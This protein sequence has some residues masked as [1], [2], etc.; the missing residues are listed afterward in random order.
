MEQM[1]RKVGVN[2][3]TMRVEYGNGQFGL[4][5]ETRTQITAC[6]DMYRVKQC[7]KEI[8]DVYTKATMHAVFMT[9]PEIEGVGNSMP[10]TH[11]LFLIKTWGEFGPP[12]AFDDL[13]SDTRLSQVAGHWIGG[14]MKHSAGLTALCCPTVNCYRRLQDQAALRDASWGCEDWNASF[15]VKYFS[16]R[17]VDIDNLIPGG[18]ANPYIVLAATF[19]AGMSGIKNKYPLPQPGEKVRLPTSLAEALE[20]LENDKVLVEALG[21]EFVRSFI[22]CKREYE[23]DVLVHNSIEEER[24]MYYKML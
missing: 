3:D 13:T 20:A 10:F 6:D 22:R 23:V 2:A 17:T 15:C 8:T 14:L 18:S 19:A 5:L 9:K 4:T 16:E 24:E 21:E 7:I 1:L 12:N 11:S